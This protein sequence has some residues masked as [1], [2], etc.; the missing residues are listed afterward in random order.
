MVCFQADISS[1]LKVQ[2]A[3]RNAVTALTKQRVRA[4]QCFIQWSYFESE[5]PL[6]FVCLK[7][8]VQQG[9]PKSSLYLSLSPRSIEALT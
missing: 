3:E 1:G 6:V 5:K 8:I 4:F 7:L 9:H 2:R